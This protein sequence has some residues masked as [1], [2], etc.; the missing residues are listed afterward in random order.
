MTNFNPFTWDNSSSLVT[1]RVL[2]LVLKDHRGE[3][4][5]IK[6]STEE[7]EITIP[8][9]ENSDGAISSFVKPSTE[10]KMQYHKAD[11]T[12]IK[13]ASVTLKVSGMLS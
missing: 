7:I 1:S 8:Q 6:D 3:T 10:G 4:L 9:E 2:S 5:T 11:V 12:V 13:G